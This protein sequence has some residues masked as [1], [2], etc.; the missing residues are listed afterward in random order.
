MLCNYNLWF[1]SEMVN[2]NFWTPFSSLESHRFSKFAFCQ[3][4][5]RW[6]S[7]AWHLHVVWILLTSEATLSTRMYWHSRIPPEETMKNYEKSRGKAPKCLVK[8]QQNMTV[9]KLHRCAQVTLFPPAM[10]CIIWFYSFPNFHVFL[11]FGLLL[12]MLKNL[13]VV[14][15]LNPSALFAISSV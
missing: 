7:E 3:G 5:E 8:V 10:P 11:P 14:A 15:W 6:I 2:I 1:S 12:S 4:S 9:V 13:L